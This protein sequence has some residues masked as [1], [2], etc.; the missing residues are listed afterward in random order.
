M[1]MVTIE[2]EDKVDELIAILD[3][4]IRQMQESLSRLNELRGLLVKLCPKSK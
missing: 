1:K 3:G 4:D 2:I